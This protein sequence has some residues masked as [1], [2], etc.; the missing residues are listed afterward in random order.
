MTLSLLFSMSESL[1]VG[2]LACFSLGEV[3]PLLDCPPLFE[4]LAVDSDSGSCCG[5]VA[6]KLEEDKEIHR[7]AD[8]RPG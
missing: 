8:T 4:V 3:C 5:A 2:A 7:N 1:S 6:E